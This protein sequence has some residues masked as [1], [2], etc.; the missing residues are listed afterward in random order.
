MSS[1][2]R[3]QPSKETPKGRIGLAFIEMEI[4]DIERANLRE[5]YRMNQR[6]D[7]S[8]SITDLLRAG[9]LDANAASLLLCALGM[10]ASLITGAVPGG[11]GK[12]TLLAA[13][14]GLI[15]PGTE[16]VTVADPD[17][18]P[19]GLAPDRGTATHPRVYLCHE[20]GSGP[21]YAYL[22][23]RDVG[24]F[25]GAIG[26]G[27]SV[28]ATLHADNLDQVKGILTRTGFGVTDRI[29][30]K[31]ELILFIEMRRGPRGI[32]RRVR[33]V[34]GSIQD[35]PPNH[36]V[37]L[38]WRPG[39][40]SFEDH[41]ALGWL[42]DLAKRKGI[43]PTRVEGAFRAAQGLFLEA[44]NSWDPSFEATR[45]KVVDFYLRSRNFWTGNE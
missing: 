29:L 10:G 45:R 14:L 30:A 13:A 16:I 36:R 33:E 3:A 20:I 35:A 5:I 11:A 32:L 41:G 23:G 40:D 24:T 17:M 7:R 2:E 4:T 19:G 12:T 15:P 6:G 27:R 44:S 38:S 39:D 28:A 18:L 43:P 1:I 26:P 9:T 31:I 42:L 22:W 21:Y 8:L 34:L 25:L 37:L